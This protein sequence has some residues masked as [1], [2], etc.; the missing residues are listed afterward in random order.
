MRRLLEHRGKTEKLAACRLIDDDILMIVVDSGHLNGSGDQHV[1]PLSG[2]ADSV[3][4]LPR[5]E[6]LELD[7]RCEH[8]ELVVVE[9]REQGH[10]FQSLRFA[11]H[12]SP[13]SGSRDPALQGTRKRDS[14]NDLIWVLR[15]AAETAIVSWPG[16]SVEAAQ[17]YEPDFFTLG[18][19]DRGRRAGHRADRGAEFI[20]DGVDG[21]F[22]NHDEALRPHG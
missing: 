8:G 20:H 10:L 15:A 5:D 12:P 18:P 22:A 16:Q 3:D 11:R 1:R 13:P 19:G 21:R 9:Q 14:Q 2:V 17:P 6:Y 4:A 7:L